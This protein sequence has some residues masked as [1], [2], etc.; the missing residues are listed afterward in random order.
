MDRSEHLTALATVD[1]PCPLCR[2]DRA[3]RVWST[4]DRA[5]AVPGVYT[6]ARC[7]ACGFLYQRPRVREDC[8]ELCYPDHYP[9]HQEPSP[10]SP[11]KE[12]P[13]RVRAVRYALARSLGYARVAHEVGIS[14]RVRA[15]ALLRRLRWACPPWVGQG[16]YLDV[17]CGSGGTLGVA[18]A[19]GW[20]VSGIEM[21]EAA[22]AK[23]RRFTDDL[24]VGDILEARF[25]DDAFD[26]VSAFHVLEHVVD[27]VAVV[28]RM[29][30][31]LTPGGRLIIEV[32]N[33]GGLG[34]RLFGRSWVGLELPRHLS[35]FTPTTLERTVRAA[36]GEVVWCWHRAQPRYYI[37]S[38]AA[39]LGDHGFTRLARCVQWR[40]V[41]GAVKLVL[42][43][44]LPLVSRAGHGEV[45][46][47][48][49]VRA[50]TPSSGPADRGARRPTN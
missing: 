15:R 24:H 3:E 14:T 35:H 17:G 10:R 22:A 44:T 36:G 40:P 13:A 34:A 16:R 39:W 8:L 33:A 19:L 2:S 29:L 18:K 38:L 45:I 42:E 37:W 6:V 50:A 32:P 41:R 25:A 28:R 26:V 31:W 7:S 30:E 49:A 20:R 21:D 27:P 11:F 48:G 23:A 12:S 47:I 43:L 1:A 9:R 46:R 5:F 4:P